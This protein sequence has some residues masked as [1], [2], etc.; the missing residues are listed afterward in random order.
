MIDEK[1]QHQFQ[2]TPQEVYAVIMHMEAEERK[3]SPT[4]SE[5]RALVDK[6]NAKRI[7]LKLNI[8][9]DRVLREWAKIYRQ[10]DRRQIEIDCGALITKPSKPGTITL[11]DEV[12]NS[13]CGVVNKMQD[14]NRMFVWRHYI[15][16]PDEIYNISHPIREVM[17]KIYRGKLPDDFLSK[18]SK[19]AMSEWLRQLG[20]SSSMYSNDLADAKE[21]FCSK[22]GL[23]S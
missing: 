15:K 2:L 17:I 16:R 5:R 19:W 12:I 10:N 7:K 9:A 22:G 18:L 1:Q 13:I 4:Q 21:D 8:T 23:N 20:M 6:L 14:Y 11:D 3:K